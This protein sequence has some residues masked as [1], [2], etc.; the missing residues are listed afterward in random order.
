[1]LKGLKLWYYSGRLHFQGP[2]TRVGPY[3]MRYDDSWLVRSRAAT[4]LGRLGDP[5]PLLP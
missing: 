5:P 3:G 4:V 1:M 2:A